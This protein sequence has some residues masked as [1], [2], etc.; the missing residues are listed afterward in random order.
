MYALDV[1]YNMNEHNLRTFMS[2]MVN[3]DIV[4][5]MGMSYFLDSEKEKKETSLQNYS[6]FFP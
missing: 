3:Q 2:R 4:S 5:L 1:R 6:Y